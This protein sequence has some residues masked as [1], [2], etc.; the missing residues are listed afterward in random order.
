[1]SSTQQWLAIM[2]SVGEGSVSG[3]MARCQSSIVDA[4][5]YKPCIQYDS[6][7]VLRDK[8]MNCYACVH[9]LY[10]DLCLFIINTDCFIQ[11]VLK[12]MFTCS[13]RWFVPKSI[14]ILNYLSSIM[15]DSSRVVSLLHKHIQIE[16]CRRE[17]NC[18]CTGRIDSLFSHYAL[19]MITCIF[20]LYYQINLE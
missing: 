15:E 17:G 3:I 18:W 9:V 1:M 16:R 5:M 13:S 7:S 20:I 2:I 14:Y 11:L 4:R 10:T 6:F 12:Y 19:G 8:Q